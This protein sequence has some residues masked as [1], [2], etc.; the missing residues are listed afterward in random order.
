MGALVVMMVLNSFFSNLIVRSY[1]HFDVKMCD[2]YLKKKSKE[3]KMKEIIFRNEHFHNEYVR[4]FFLCMLEWC[5]NALGILV[6]Y[7][8]IHVVLSVCVHLFECMCLSIHFYV[9]RIM[10][11]LGQILCQAMGE[12]DLFY[13]I[14]QS[15]LPP[16]SSHAY[17]IICGWCVGFRA[18]NVKKCI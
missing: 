8:W 1:S 3:E 17:I 11:R 4:W 7:D 5:L 16:S 2:F 13:I 14:I 15:T 10:S 9:I 12:R 6:W 18:D